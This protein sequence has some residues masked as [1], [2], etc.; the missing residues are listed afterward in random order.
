MNQ[1]ELF[2]HWV[3]VCGYQ[4]ILKHD[5]YYNSSSY[6]HIYSR[7]NYMYNC[8]NCASYFKLHI[9]G[10]FVTD[11]KNGEDSYR[12]CKEQLMYKALA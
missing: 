12:T 11:I 7:K 3:N 1:L 4:S 6:N 2:K 9:D 5:W 10:S 8:T